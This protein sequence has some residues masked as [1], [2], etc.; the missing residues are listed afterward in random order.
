MLILGSRLL[1]TAIMSLQTGGQLAVTSRPVIDPADLRIHAY[2]I[3]GPLL[4]EQP[5]FIRTADIREYGRLGMIIDSTDEII[6]VSDVIK[7]ENLYKLGFPLIGLTVIDDQKR[8]LGK[9]DDY[10]LE[11]NSY[12]IQQLHVRR[13]FLKGISDTGLIIGRSQILEIN[14]T[15]I[16][17]RSPSVPVAAPVMNAIRGEFINPLRPRGAQAHSTTNS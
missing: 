5:S 3:E 6:G 10:T 16:V 1:K 7:I 8:R 4:T 9:V 13:G 14:D 17:V 12:V 2:E 11:T 15:N